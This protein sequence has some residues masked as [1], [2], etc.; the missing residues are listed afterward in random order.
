M[1]S[2]SIARPIAT[3]PQQAL[4]PSAQVIAPAQVQKSSSAAA[5]VQLQIAPKSAVAV[6]KVQALETV[7]AQINQ[8]V[9]DETAL[10]S[11]TIELVRAW[12]LRLAMAPASP[13]HYQ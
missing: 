9:Q 2:R 3:K 1:S 10:K 8:L 12:S 7:R 11:K 6:P 5:H 13:L 4:A